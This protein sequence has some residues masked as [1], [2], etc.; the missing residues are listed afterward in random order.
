MPRIKIGL[1]LFLLTWGLQT[2]RP[3]AADWLITLEGELIETR[4]PWTIEEKVLT[5]TDAA[6]EEHRL[7]L[8]GVDLEASEETTALKAGKPY[9]PEPKVDGPEASAAETPAVQPEERVVLYMTSWCGYCRRTSQLLTTLGVPFVEKDIEKDLQAAEDYRKKAGGYRGVPVLDVGGRIVRGYR[10]TL[11]HK[12]V[13]KLRR[14]EER[15]T[16]TASDG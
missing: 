2:A 15:A 16:R 10:P 4:G 5:Y 9:V 7:D 11:I 12:Y 3:A 1:S 14:E 6:G 13:A 8:A